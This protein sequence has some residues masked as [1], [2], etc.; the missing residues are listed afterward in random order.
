MPRRLELSPLE[1]AF[2]DEYLIDGVGARAARDAGYAAKSAA[3]TAF[4]LV[5]KPHIKAAIRKAL[6]AQQKRTL[7]TA[8][9]V[10]LDIDRI[11]A[12]A[13]GK[14]EF[15][16][17]LYGKIALAKHYKLLTD[18]H[19]VTGKNGGPMEFTEVRRTIVDP[20]A[21]DDA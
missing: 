19:E 21:A 20:K 16:A 13:E 18:K 8:D 14:G 6:L 9:K 10:L 7:I 1:Q 3:V 15:N 4:K 5:R 2:V 11:A 12:K 17:A